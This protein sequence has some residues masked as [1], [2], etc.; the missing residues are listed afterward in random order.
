MKKL[1]KFGLLGLVAHCLLLAVILFTFPVAV[2]DGTHNYWHIIKVLFQGGSLK[3]FFESCIIGVP[4]FGL[5]IYNTWP[6]KKKPK[7]WVVK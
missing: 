3:G 4:L 5:A 1:I 6:G 2:I 7:M